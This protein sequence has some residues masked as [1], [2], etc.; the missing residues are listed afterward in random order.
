MAS[1]L[2]DVP[3]GNCRAVGKRLV[4]VISELGEDFEGVG[5]DFQDVMF[6]LQVAGD[7][8]GVFGLVILGHRE[9]DGECLNGLG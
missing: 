9:A 1:E 7:G 5:L 6:G 8:F 3:R 4:V 2:G